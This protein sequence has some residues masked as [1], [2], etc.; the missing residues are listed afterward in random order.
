MGSLLVRAIEKCG[1]PRL[2]WGVEEILLT[3]EG[4]PNLVPSLNRIRKV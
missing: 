3:R 2:Q 1:E 4:K